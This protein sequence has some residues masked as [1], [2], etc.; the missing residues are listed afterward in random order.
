MRREKEL[1]ETIE[2]VEKTIKHKAQINGKIDYR[3]VQ[4]L[5][6]LIKARTAMIC[7]ESLSEQ[8]K[9]REV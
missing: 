8:G 9:G 3:E 4:A 2:E 7:A 6:E 5:A 1:D